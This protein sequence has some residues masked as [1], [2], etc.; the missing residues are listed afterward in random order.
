MRCIDPNGSRRFV[1]L[2][3]A[4]LAIPIAWSQQS[5][6]VQEQGGI[7]FVSGGFG[8]EERDQLHAMQDRF[9]LKLVFALDSGSYLADVNVRIMDR[10]GNTL[11]ETRTNGPILMANLAAGNYT[12]VADRDN[13]EKE[14]TVSVRSGG[15]TEVTFTWPAD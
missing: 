9:T 15:T 6:Q 10:H 4:L 3:I 11:L 8:S 14:R 7:A 2:L 12:V 13:S 1:A 5:L